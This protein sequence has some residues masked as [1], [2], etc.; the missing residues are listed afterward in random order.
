MSK[1][2]TLALSLIIFFAGAHQAFAGFGVSPGQITEENLV[3]GSRFESTIYLVQGNPELDLPVEATVDS[4]EIKD[5]V[6]FKNGDKF[7]IP[8]GVQQ[9]PL[10]IVVEVPDN[11]D[12]GIY[13]AFIRVKTVPDQANTDGTVAIAIGGRVDLN[14]TV[15]DDVIE[16]Y[17]VTSIEIL[18]IREG[19]DPAI[20]VKVKNTGNVPVAPSLA[21]FEL[22]NRF[23]TVRLGF[24]ESD[25][26]KKTPSFSEDEQ[27]LNFPIDVRFAPGEYWGHVKIHDEEGKVIKELKTVF[28][29]KEVTL[30][31]KIVGYW[32]IIVI[33][34]ALY[35]VH[36]IWKK[37]RK[38]SGR[39]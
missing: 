12:L 23:G 29:V 2:L 15:G 27:Q 39:R 22:F 18:D 20:N 6:T 1:F 28:D 7:T 31:E 11:A 32:W 4:D 14:V 5:W 35:L 16:E 30:F 25:K 37:K 10:E 9:Y 21:T 24:A 17:E 36:S 34:I 13:K 8:S 38:K 3:P 19:D 26:F 33:L